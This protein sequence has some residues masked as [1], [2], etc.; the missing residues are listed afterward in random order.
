MRANSRERES[1]RARDE[2]ASDSGRENERTCVQSIESRRASEGE[3]GR[4]EAPGQDT[5]AQRDGDA[6]LERD[7]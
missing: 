6:E 7:L 3:R 1:A 4:G 2:G 5:P